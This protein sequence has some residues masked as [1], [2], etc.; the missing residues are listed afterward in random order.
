M[1]EE[2]LKSKLSTFLLFNLAYKKAF[3]VFKTSRETFLKSLEVIAA[4]GRAPSLI[5]DKSLTAPIRNALAVTCVTLLKV[6]IVNP[7]FVYETISPVLIPT[8]GFG[9]ELVT[10]L[11]PKVS[12]LMVN[13]A[14]GSVRVVD[15]D[16]TGSAVNVPR[17]AV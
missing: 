5:L 13:W 2:V 12:A 17:P 9:L 11:T 8:N 1:I 4:D 16:K 15:C 7:C 3:E 6:G 10:V 14:P